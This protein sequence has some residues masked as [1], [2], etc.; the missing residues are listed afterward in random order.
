MIWKSN[1]RNWTENPLN[2]SIITT[3]LLPNQIE[4]ETG[5]SYILSIHDREG[6]FQV[7]FPFQTFFTPSTYINQECVNI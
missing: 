1:S 4:V 6:G 7:H 3:K 2:P 5:G